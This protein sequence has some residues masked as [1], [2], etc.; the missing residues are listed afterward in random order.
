VDP[1]YLHLTDTR[2]LGDAEKWSQDSI[3][4]EQREQVESKGTTRNTRVKKEKKKK[5]KK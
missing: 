4:I 1:L 5:K 3:Q 2:C